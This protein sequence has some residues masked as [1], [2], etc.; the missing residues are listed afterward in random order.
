MTIDELIVKLSLDAAGYKQGAKDTQA[1]AT[2][3]A[4]GLVQSAELGEKGQA[5]SHKRTAAS[6]MAMGKSIVDS[7]AKVQQSFEGMLRTGLAFLAMFAGAKGLSKI[8]PER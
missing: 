2:K 3:L 1:A 7:N 6:A 4:A 8:S 5:A